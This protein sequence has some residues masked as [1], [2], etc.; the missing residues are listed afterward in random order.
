MGGKT[1]G[2]PSALRQK[3]KIRQPNAGQTA[4]TL[5]ENYEP[6]SL[7]SRAEPSKKN[8]NSYS[9]VFRR[10][11]KG[12]GPRTAG[13]LHRQPGAGGG[14]AGRD[15]SNRH[16]RRK[17]NI[18]QT[19]CRAGVKKKNRERRTQLIGKSKGRENRQEQPGQNESHVGVV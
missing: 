18:G 19:N 14:T 11:E 1:W 5:K 6:P 12:G 9:K 8:E 3:T 4:L 2:L 13:R 15:P 17:A 16:T 7:T 10:T